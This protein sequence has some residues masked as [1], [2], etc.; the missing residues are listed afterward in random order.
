V[1]ITNLGGMR[2]DLPIGDI[3]LADVVGVM[4]FENVI[5]ALLLTGEELDVM[6]GQDSAAIGGVYR[7]NFRWYLKATEEAL[8]PD[9]FYTVLV[10]D[11]MYAGGDD[12]AHLAVY[13]PDAY[14][15]AINWRQPVIDWIIAQNSSPDNPIDAAFS[16]LSSP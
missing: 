6:L 1:A 11:F 12:Y 7:D 4:P 5:V 9:G 15:T 3:T 2:A 16:R 14:D 10:N 13:D 8:D